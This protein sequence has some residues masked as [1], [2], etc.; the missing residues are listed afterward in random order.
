M[1][2]IGCCD[3]GDWGWQGAVEGVSAAT[4]PALGSGGGGCGDRAGEW[5]IPTWNCRFCEEEFDEIDKHLHIGLANPVATT[6]P[7]PL[8]TPLATTTASPTTCH[9]FPLILSAIYPTIAILKQGVKWDWDDKGPWGGCR[10]R[11]D[12]G[13]VGWSG[14]GCGGVEWV[15]VRWGGVG[16]EKGEGR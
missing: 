5:V 12:W 13:G 1:G 15:G 8:A 6:P 3:L 11:P 9:F 2:E 10:R 14:S 4:G 16:R 7:T